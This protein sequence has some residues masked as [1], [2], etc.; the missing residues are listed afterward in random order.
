MDAVLEVRNPMA[1]SAE[2]SVGVNAAPVMDV[3]VGF[4]VIL[5]MYFP[6]SL[7]V[8]QVV[9]SQARSAYL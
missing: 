1:V 8:R 6:V 3:D 5:V 2:S 7:S 4:S 9:R